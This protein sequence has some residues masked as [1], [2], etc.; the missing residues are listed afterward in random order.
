[1]QRMVLYNNRFLYDRHAVHAVPAE[2]NAELA[3]R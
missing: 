1:M 2:F 3:G